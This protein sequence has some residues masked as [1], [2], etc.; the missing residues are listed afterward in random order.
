MARGAASSPTEGIDLAIEHVEQLI[1][2]VVAG[3]TDQLE[4]TERT[5]TPKSGADL[6][7][8]TTSAP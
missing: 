2:E 3:R 6:A 4:G 8:C 5:R 7:P 1:H